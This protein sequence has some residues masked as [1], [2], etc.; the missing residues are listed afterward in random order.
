MKLTSKQLL[1]QKIQEEKTSSTNET[2]KAWWKGRLEM[3]SEMPLDAQVKEFANISRSPRADEESTRLEMELYE[4][5]LAIQQWAQEPE[6]ESEEVKN[7]HMLSIMRL[8]KRMLD[9]KVLTATSKEVATTIL[10]L[11]GFGSFI[12]S[13]L[14]GVRII[15]GTSPSFKFKKLTKLKGG[16]TIPIYQFMVGKEDPIEWQLRMFGE[17]MD[18]SMD[19]AFDRRVEFQPDAWQRKVLDSIDRNHSTLVVGKPS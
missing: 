2:S 12:E 15:T 9:R 6:P 13:M 5:N 1:L 14:D 4:L 16:E 10:T 17:Y 18:R 11:F 19:S 8:I 3:L 7:R